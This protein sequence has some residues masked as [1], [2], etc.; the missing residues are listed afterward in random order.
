MSLILTD[1]QKVALALDI[2]TAAGNPA[3]VD[4]APEWSSSGP[5]TLEIAP[6][7][8]SAEAITDGP[9]GMAQVSVR[10]DADLGAGVQNITGILDIEVVAAQAASLSINAGVPELK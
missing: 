8:L 9:L 5:I 10:A 6:D 3:S 7:G 2:R 1:E 4:G